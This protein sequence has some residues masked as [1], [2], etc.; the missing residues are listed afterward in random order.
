MY[1]PDKI[2][3]RG[4]IR[5]ISLISGMLLLPDLTSK[6]FPA[7]GKSRMKPGFV[8]YQWGKDWDIPTI[9]QNLTAAEIHGIELRVEHAHG[10]TIDLSKEKRKE[11]RKKFKNSPVEIVG[12]GTNQQFD[13]PDRKMLVKSVETTM[14]YIR[15]SAD[16]GG[17]G[18]KV[19]PNQFHEGVPKSKTIEQI[20]KSLNQLATYG[21]DFGQKIRLE[22]HGTD[23]SDIDNFK[24]IMDV[25]DHP[26]VGVCWNCNPEDLSG[27]G[28]ESNFNLLRDRLGDTCHVRELDDH[29]YPYQTLMNLLVKMNW[30][31]WVLFEFRTDP[32][33]KV[34]SLISQRKIWEWMVEKAKTS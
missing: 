9:I 12:M 5:D 20:G 27:K 26:N 11:V 15:L 31:G 16:I 22:V 7:Y 29:S 4:F 10:V 23:T 1:L 19:K 13:Y 28:I 2:N 8:T 17:S 34:A 14:K 6:A 30:K 3:R 18:V 33:D 21:A 25:A 32:A 24:A